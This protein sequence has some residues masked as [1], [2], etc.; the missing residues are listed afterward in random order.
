MSKTLTVM[1]AYVGSMC[2]DTSSAFYS[3]TTGWLNDAQRDAGRRHLWSCLIDDDYTFPTVAAQQ[4]YNT[5][6]R[7]DREIFVVN[8]TLGTTLT[9]KNIRNWWVDRGADYSSGT[10]QGGD[11]D[12][13]V[14]TPEASKIKLD[15]TPT[16]VATIAFPYQ[17]T[18]VDLSGSTDVPSITNIE[19]YLERYAISMG[20]AYY[21]K[22]DK[23]DWWMQK[24]EIE[25]AK[26]VSAEQNKINQIFM[27]YP[28]N[29]DKS[30]TRLTGNR[31]YDSL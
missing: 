30:A 13:Y 19:T 23:A 18:V 8:V 14:V 22:Y 29:R 16:R 17:L 12:T 9:R 11:P 3:L 25:L 21:K 31:S 10:L 1:Q 27:R 24:A 2:N 15:P 20:H 7:F 5:P 6:T 26:L 4:L 28:M